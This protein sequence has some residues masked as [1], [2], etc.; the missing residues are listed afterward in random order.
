M[1]GMCQRIISIEDLLRSLKPGKIHVNGV[2]YPGVKIFIG[3]LIKP[4]NDSHQY[5]SFYAQGG[6][7]KFS[8]LG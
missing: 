4:L 6:E 2:I 1:E 3:T 5:V 7:I 8:S